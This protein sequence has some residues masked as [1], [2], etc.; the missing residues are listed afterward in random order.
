MV[1]QSLEELEECGVLESDLCNTKQ[2]GNVCYDVAF[3]VSHVRFW[4]LQIIAV[5]TPKLLFLGHILHVLHEEGRPPSIQRLKRQRE[6]D[7]QATL[8]LRRTYKVTKY[9]MLS[10]KISIRGRLLRSEVFHL[11]AMMVIE[12]V[13]IFGQYSLYG[14]YLDPRYACTRF[15]CPHVVD[16]FL[17]KM[18]YLYVKAMKE[19]MA[20]R[21][22]Y[23][24]TL[25]TPPPSERKVF[26]S[27]GDPVSQNCVNLELQGRKLGVNNGKSRLY[28]ESG[29][30]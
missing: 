7:D 19:C 12:A 17:I 2:P 6:L 8:F 25:V 18:L 3:P 20:R 13:F 28:G 4:T 26:K 22:D 14:L 9:T 23:T 1:P 10:G 5:A 24:V 21:Q 30:I 16:S 11:L 29:G 27:Q 15:P